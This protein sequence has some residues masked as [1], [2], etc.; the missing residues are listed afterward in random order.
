MSWLNGGREA[1][2]KKEGLKDLGLGAGRRMV[3][4]R[5]LYF[6]DDPDPSRGGDT[7]NL[8]RQTAQPSITGASPIR[9][10]STHQKLDPIDHTQR[11]SGGL[12]RSNPIQAS[13]STLTTIH[14]PTPSIRD[15]VHPPH[16]SSY[17]LSSRIPSTIFSFPLLIICFLCPARS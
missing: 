7:R 3:S 2:R 1:G 16:Y 6:D 14:S 8:R 10:T 5:F 13:S 15:T 4:S 11:T 9:F 17:I 12:N